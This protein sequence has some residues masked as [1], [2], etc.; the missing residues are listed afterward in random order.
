MYFNLSLGKNSGGDAPL[1]ETVLTYVVTGAS[2]Q[3]CQLPFSGRQRYVVDWDDGSAKETI[4]QDYAPPAP[5]HSYGSIGTYNITISPSGRS[6]EIPRFRSS[7]IQQ[8][9]LTQAVKD[10]YT[11]IVIGGG[12]GLIRGGGSKDDA[13]RS[14][15]VKMNGLTSVTFES[16]PE[17][18]TDVQYMFLRTGSDKTVDLTKFDFRFVNNYKGMF[19]SAGVV[20]TNI[21]KWNFNGLINNNLEMIYMFLNDSQSAHTETKI[22]SS[23]EYGK[24]LIAISNYADNNSSIRNITMNMGDSTYTASPEIPS[25]LAKRNLIDNY[26][27]TIVDGGRA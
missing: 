9:S 25:Y 1:T 26:G 18:Q 20:T 23:D 21:S 19:Q 6:L 2:N 27:F 13:F 14:A 24:L 3:T 4:D 8:G 5:T 16:T 10:A 17:R 15:F 11:T 22:A 7:A 12:F